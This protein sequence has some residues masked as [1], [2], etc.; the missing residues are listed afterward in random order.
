[1]NT[2]MIKKL[3][4]LGVLLIGGNSVRHKSS[5]DCAAIDAITP[6][7]QLV[8][9]LDPL[10][11]EVAIKSVVSSNHTAVYSNSSNSSNS[12]NQIEHSSSASSTNVPDDD[13][14]NASEMA[15]IQISASG[16]F[17]NLLR[18]KG[19]HIVQIAIPT[20]VSMASVGSVTPSATNMTIHNNVPV[21][22]NSTAQSSNIDNESHS[23]NVIELDPNWEKI[24]EKFKCRCC[25]DILAA[26]H[27]LTCCNNEARLCWECLK[28]LN[29]KCMFCRGDCSQP[30]RDQQMN[31]R[32]V[33]EVHKFVKRYPHS[34]EHTVWKEKYEKF[35][36]HC[37]T[38]S[39]QHT[40]MDMEQQVST[41][42]YVVVCVTLITGFSIYLIINV[43]LRWNQVD[44]KQ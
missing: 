9:P 28:K 38:R 39:N 5:F 6:I 24:V 29:G 26:P 17:N 22:T 21:P 15:T 33:S 35:C 25:F 41:I 8:D 4:A 23:N 10:T 12:S 11:T 34:L 1:M 43:G 31:L 3:G 44:S 42:I 37:R 7:P 27:V 19:N 40:L 36:N 13:A 2:V 20:R 14:P 32:I 18:S 30:Q 16:P